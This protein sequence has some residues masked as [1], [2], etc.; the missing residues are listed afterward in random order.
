MRPFA[1]TV[2]ALAASMMVPLAWAFDPFT[3][4]DIRLVAIRF[5]PSTIYRFMF[6]TQPT[7]T[8]SLSE[9]LRRTTYSFRKLSEADAA[10]ATPL[11][12]RVVTV[13]ASDTVASLARRMAFD[14]AQEQ[15]FRVLNGLRPDEAVRPGDRVKIIAD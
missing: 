15:R 1:K 14:T 2:F 6:V 9:P 12:V 8:A 3:V 11:R 10:R 5:D 7:D 4:R 13:G